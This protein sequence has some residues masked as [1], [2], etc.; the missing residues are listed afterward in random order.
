MYIKTIPLKKLPFF[1]KHVKK[2]NNFLKKT[3]VLPN[4]A[5]IHVK[6]TNKGKL[7]CV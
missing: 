5:D 6:G 1:A 2:C 4:S 7:S 3:K